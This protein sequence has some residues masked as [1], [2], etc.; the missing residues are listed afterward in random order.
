MDLSAFFQTQYGRLVLL[1]SGIF[2]ILAVL[3]IPSYFIV[4]RPKR[5]TTEWMQR[6]D[7]PQFG[8]MTVQRLRWSDI[9]W[10][11]LSS[12]CAPMLRLS[13]YLL[14]YLRRGWLQAVS[15]HLDSLVNECLIPCAI[16]AALLYLL[17]RS[18]LDQPLPAICGALLGGMMQMENYLAAILTVLSF[19]FL[20]RYVAADADMSLF[21]HSALLLLSLMFYGIALLRYWDLIWLAPV[22]LTAYVYMQLYRWRRGDETERGA[23][24]A[25]SVLLLFFMAVGAVV[26]A[27]AYYCYRY[28]QWQ[29]ILNLQQFWEVMSVRLINRV[30]GLI[31]LKHPLTVICAEDIILLLIGGA[32]LVP[33]VHGAVVRR[34]SL[35]LA[36]LLLLPS[37]VAMWLLS[38]T[39]LLVPVLTLALSWVYHILLERDY[40]SLTIIFT[41]L[42]AVGFLAEYYI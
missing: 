13:G 23:A 24:L 1:S 41:V 5:G 26:C 39:Y 16:I 12:F 6:I 31:S 15:Q 22:Y 36:L 8:A 34:N 19:I 38:G 7:V 11:A 32:A 14:K 33:V 35:C 28:N 20:W 30:Q 10:V 2:A 21:A 27:W 25:V 42:T 40:T 9:A 17:L 37:F 18:M 3:I 29:H 4:I